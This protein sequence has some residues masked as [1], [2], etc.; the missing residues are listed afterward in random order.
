MGRIKLWPNKIEK[1][2][3]VKDVR[4][5]FTIFIFRLVQTYSLKFQSAKYLLVESFCNFCKNIGKFN[6]KLCNQGIITL[7]GNRTTIININQRLH[8]LALFH[9][10]FHTVRQTSECRNTIQAMT[11]LEQNFSQHQ[12]KGKYKVILFSIYYY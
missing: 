12:K 8:T 9:I 4:Q 1:K 3:S 6:F 10:I 11:S 2:N 7:I 5:F